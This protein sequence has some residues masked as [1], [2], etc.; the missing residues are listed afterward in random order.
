MTKFHFSSLYIIT[1]ITAR[2]TKQKKNIKETQIE[3][4]LLGL[5]RWLRS[6]KC[7]LLSQSTGIWFSELTSD[8]HRYLELQIPRSSTPASRAVVLVS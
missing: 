3:K 8:N 6:S 5:K 7:L 2:S 4:N 1:V